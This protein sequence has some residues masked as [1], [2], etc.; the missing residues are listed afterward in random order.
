MSSARGFI[1]ATDNQIWF[2]VWGALL[3]PQITRS[4]S[5]Y[6]G[7]YYCTD[8]Q[9]IWCTRGFTT[10]TDNQIWFSIWARGFT[11]ATDNQIWFSVEGLLIPFP[12]ITRILI[13][14]S[15]WAKGLLLLQIIVIWV[16]LVEIHVWVWDKN[17]QGDIARL[18]VFTQFG[19]RN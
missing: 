15:V 14:F 2:S 17:T 7:L 6:E 10:A 5:V 3:L 13:W 8:N 16:G 1:S 4:G 9:I 18:F 19:I 12:Q 11:T